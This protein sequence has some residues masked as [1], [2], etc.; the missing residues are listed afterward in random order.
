MLKSYKVTGIAMGL[1]ILA[2]CG[3]TAAAEP[4][5][6]DPIT[7]TAPAP[8]AKVVT[9]TVDRVPQACMKALDDAEA[10]VAT[11]RKGILLSVKWPDIAVRSLRAG[12]NADSVA[13]QGITTDVKGL[14]ADYVSITE[15]LRPEV[16]SYNRDSGSCRAAR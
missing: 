2:A 1:V 7:V 16:A 11:A 12:L 5:A 8:A 9:Q 3:G 4:K 13:L 10:V 6:A 15:E 14:N